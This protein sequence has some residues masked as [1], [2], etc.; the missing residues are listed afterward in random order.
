M[1]QPSDACIDNGAW[2]CTVSCET[3]HSLFW[4]GY[5]FDYNLH[6]QSL[7]T[8]LSERDANAQLK[9]RLANYLQSIEDLIPTDIGLC[10]QLLNVRGRPRE[11]F[12]REQ[13]SWPKEGEEELVFISGVFQET[14]ENCDEA[15]NEKKG[16]PHV[17]QFSLQILTSF[18]GFPTNRSIEYKVV[19]R[20]HGP[21]ADTWLEQ[22]LSNIIKD[23]RVG[24]DI[25]R[26]GF[27]FF[28]ARFF[29]HF[30]GFGPNVERRFLLNV[31]PKDIF[32]SMSEEG[33]PTSD[34]LPFAEERYLEKLN[35]AFSLGLNK[36][37][38]QPYSMK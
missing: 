37:L 14:E 5:S 38:S 19:H 13:P 31:S 1:E 27:E 11:L 17:Q 7:E 3:S 23:S 36:D 9:T 4:G 16:E 29:G 32:L 15:E 21:Y 10:D 2:R 34:S 33:L 24:I 28:R 30:F 22:P 20:Y 6:C 26:C 8:V 18:A 25:F 12:L 35:Q